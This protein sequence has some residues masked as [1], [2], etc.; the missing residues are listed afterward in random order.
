MYRIKK[1]IFCS[2]YNG[3]IKIDFIVYR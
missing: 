2:R 3:T 1:L